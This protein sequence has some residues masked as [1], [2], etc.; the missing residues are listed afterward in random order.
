MPSVIGKLI[1]TNQ[2]YEVILGYEPGELLGQPSTSVYLDPADRLAWL[3]AMDEKGSLS[4]YEIRLKRKDGSPVWVA[5]NVAPIEF[6][7]K[8]AIIGINQDV[9]ERKRIEAALQE[10]NQKY[11]DDPINC[12]YGMGTLNMITRGM[13]G[14]TLFQVVE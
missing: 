3:A 8:G 9:T 14:Y 10:S 13:P 5:I 11:I 2:P 12:G 1:Y 6:G 7:G 4:D